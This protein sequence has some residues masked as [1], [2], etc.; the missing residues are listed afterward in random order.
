MKKITQICWKYKDYVLISIFLFIYYFPKIIYTCNQYKE[1]IFDSQNFIVWDYAKS[2]GVIPFKDIFYP[3]GLFY[4]YKDQN[5]FLTF[6]YF[7]LI[8]FLFVVIYRAIKYF[9]KNSFLSFLL[10]VLLFLFV[11]HIT[12]IDTFARYAIAVAGVLLFSLN[13]VRQ[14]VILGRKLF[15]SGVCV[16]LCL[17]FIPDQGVYLLCVI[18]LITAVHTV[19]INHKTKNKYV[20]LSY[21]SLFYGLGLI[22]GLIPGIVY[23]VHTDTLVSHISHLNLL[24]N[25][26]DYAKAPYISTLKSKDEILILSVLI[27][28]FTYS[29]YSFVFSKKPERAFVIFA[30]SLLLIMVEQKSVM[31]SISTSL[32]FIAFLQVIFLSSALVNK[33]KLMSI[34]EVGKV[35]VLFVL[36]YVFVFYVGLTPVYRLKTNEDK[37][38]RVQNFLSLRNQKKYMSVVS[39]IKKDTTSIPRIYSFPNDP[40]FYMLFHQKPPYFLNIYDASSESSQERQIDYIKTMRVDYFIYNTATYATQ[41]GVPDIIRG[42]YLINYLFT[43]FTYY[44]TVE[45]FLIFKKANLIPDF[46]RNQEVYKYFS[47]IDL[48]HVPYVEGKYKKESF[49]ILNF[50]AIDNF[51]TQILKYPLNTRNTTLLIAAKK[52]NMTDTKL[53][54][55]S[56]DQVS[57]ITLKECVYP[58]VCIINLK[59][60]PLFFHEKKLTRV[61]IE[62][63]YDVLV[64][65]RK[66][67][68]KSIFW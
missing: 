43:H 64:S 34:A 2:T 53:S 38:V 62:G 24:F 44:K 60:I 7:F 51:N 16:S 5:V 6:L 15:Y 14:N 21:L 17:S 67:K 25:I 33:K 8:L 3:Y 63:G 30:I 18:P 48:G 39:E 29:I 45:N 41:D 40:I 31:R 66:I 11:E 27:C 42:N 61:T 32:T 47:S 50:S 68:D 54:L 28:S 58:D 57:H 59:R 19:L 26:A 20:L 13:V 37:C 1:L 10:F 9:W 49:G 36:L 23:L 35:T 12:G 65:T 52:Q 55:W 56:H 4:Y 46:T 22:L